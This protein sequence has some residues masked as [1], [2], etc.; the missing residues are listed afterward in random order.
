[1]SFPFF[2]VLAFTDR[3]FAGNPAGV[4]LLEDRWWPDES[5]QRIATENNLPE[6]AWLCTF[7]Q[8]PTRAPFSAIPDR[9]GTRPNFFSAS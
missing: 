8:D 6:T 2:V 9:L 7:L 5:L 4:C 3:L 1:M